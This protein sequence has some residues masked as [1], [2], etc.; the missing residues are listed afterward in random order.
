[1]TIDEFESELR[2]A[3]TSAEENHSRA[4]RDL[5][6][7]D[8]HPMS[9]EYKMNQ[10]MTLMAGGRVAGLAEALNLL[11]GEDYE[12]RLSMPTVS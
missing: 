12:P 2:G 9:T 3:L 6:L 1:M 10:W 7:M 8:A 5:E 4:M 11:T